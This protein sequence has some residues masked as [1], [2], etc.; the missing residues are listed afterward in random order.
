[1]RRKQFFCALALFL[2]LTTLLIPL[3]ASAAEKDEYQFEYTFYVSNPDSSY[4]RATIGFDG[5]K[6]TSFPVD[7]TKT[8]MVGTFEAQKGRK[9][10]LNFDSD[11]AFLHLVCYYFDDSIKL[12][13]VNPYED[14]DISFLSYAIG[15]EEHDFDGYAEDGSLI[16][17]G[18]HTGSYTFSIPE[19]ATQFYIK[20]HTSIG[21]PGELFFYVTIVDA[22][23]P[24]NQTETSPADVNPGEDE[25]VEINPEIIEPSSPKKTDAVTAAAVSVTGALAAA[26]ALGSSS[27]EKG[28]E[29][30]KKKRYR[31]YVYKGFGDAITK[32]AKPVKIYARV[33]QIIDGKEYD[34]PEQTEKISVSGQNLTV[35]PTG[36]EGAYMSAELTAD[37]ATEAE[38]ATVT[39]TL[40][41]PGGSIRRN[42]VFRLVGEPQIAF[43]GGPVDG[44]WDTTVCEDTVQ[45]VA[46]EGGREK[47][48]FVIFDA[49]EEPKVIQFHDNDGF[50]IDCEKDPKMGFTYYALIDNKTDRAEKAA[51]IFADKEDREIVIEAVFEDGTRIRNSFTV[52][53]YPEDL[54]V[55]P[56]KDIVKND[57]LIIDTKENPEAKEGYAKIPPVIFDFTVCY[58]DEKGKAVIKKNPSCTVEDPTDNGR[59][60]RLFSDNFEYRTSHMGAAGVALFPLNTLPCLPEPY[61]AE[62]TVKHDTGR[63]HFEGVIPLSV[64]GERPSRPSSAEW[65]SAYNWLMRDIRYF[66]IDN[67][68]E[69]SAFLRNIGDH[70]AAEIADVRK[71]IIEAG[72]SFYDEYGEAYNQFSDLMSKYLVV[73]GCLV[74]AGDYALEYIFKFYFAGFGHITAKFL[75][76]LKNL[77]ATYI[78]EYMANGNLDEAPDFLETVLKSSE[79]ALSAAI[80]GMFFGDDLKGGVDTTLS[81]GTRTMRITAPPVT[82][83]IKE[84]LG[85]VVAVYLLTSFARHYNYGPGEEKGDVYRSTIAAA[86]DLGYASLKAWFLDYVTRYCSGLFERIGKYCGEL[87][88]KMCGQKIAEAA[89]KAGRE[90]FE[91][92]IRLGL[93][94]DLRGLTRESLESARA[95]RE[96]AAQAETKFQQ[97]LAGDVAK[98]LG[99]VGAGADK[100]IKDFRE[101]TGDLGN[102]GAGQILNYLMGG[103]KDDES[104][105]RGTDVKDVIYESL[106]EW[107]GIKPGKIYS[108]PLSA[109]PMDV[110]LRVEDGKIIIGMLGYYAEIHIL[111]NI[112]ALCDLM[113]ES[114]FSWLSALWQATTPS[115]DYRSIP[116]MRDQMRNS[117]EIISKELDAQ[118]QRLENLQWSYT[119]Y[120]RSSDRA[121][122]A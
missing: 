103:S 42:V 34:C 18:E 3:T 51:D 9:V 57:H 83:Q 120:M 53:L 95:A 63:L 106:N 16:A 19:N 23:G 11:G 96:A 82:E 87:Y 111:E 4:T 45:M 38:E 37:P 2:F 86:A 72:V 58:V 78:G 105:S 43:P 116:D 29:E 40:S 73:A 69:L 104:A 89:Q 26:G 60:G 110:S 93:K 91:S 115:T 97:E 113:Y 94:T 119:E 100:W 75:N 90:A 14:G 84:I 114:F 31:M 67:N 76:P 99:E 122:G 71:A 7:T 6:M 39:F 33:S 44:R 109:N 8:S 64:S 22:D 121:F 79:E 1:M 50:I 30:E 32:G 108:G 27:G 36:I 117:V 28:S 61:E 47:L 80:T 77:L 25:G 48:R 66:G 46:G 102:V 92:E 118:K 17:G 85:Y 81:L 107:L 62:M 13:P 101:D 56:N 74:K 112:S 88:R 12:N 98:K 54:S 49:M 35:R 41:G 70:S 21:T 10:I 55:I 15:F 68:E 59:Y 52:E 24:V 20:W 65:Q 5:L